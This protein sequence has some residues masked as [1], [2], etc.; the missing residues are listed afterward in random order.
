DYPH[1]SQKPPPTA[2][3]ISREIGDMRCMVRNMLSVKRVQCALAI[4]S[5]VSH[6]ADIDKQARRG[7]VEY[8]RDGLICLAWTA[9]QLIVYTSNA[10][11]R[12]LFESGKFF[13][14][15]TELGSREVSKI[16][17]QLRKQEADAKDPQKRKSAQNGKKRKKGDKSKKGE[18]S[19]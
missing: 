7:A 14:K 9:N 10:G 6:N 2:R 13:K 1:L 4:Q 3:V 19:E 17:R 5:S 12:E 8:A 11:M 16:E 18:K 15:P